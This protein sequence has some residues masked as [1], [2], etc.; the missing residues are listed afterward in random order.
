MV[1]E[2]DGGFK[3][4]TNANTERGI[5]NF[6]NKRQYAYD[7]S[8]C[9]L[10]AKRDTSNTQVY[11]GLNAKNGNFST[12]DSFAGVQDDDSVTYKELGTC[13]GTTSSTTVSD[14]AVD[15]SWTDYKI[16]CTSSNIKLYIGGN[17]KV[18]KTTNRPTVR[19]QPALQVRSMSTG[20]LSGSIRY[21]EVY[22]T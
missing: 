9:I 19:M 7:D 1:D 21:M 4:E 3:I 13:D 17:L 12:T 2:A 20:T 8:I 6:N 22:N 16:E 11:A 18:T 5:I 14:I 10:V 15:T